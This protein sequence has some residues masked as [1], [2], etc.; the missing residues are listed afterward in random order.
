MNMQMAADNARKMHMSKMQNDLKHKTTQV[1]TKSK[2]QNTQVR[3]LAWSKTMCG[4]D[5]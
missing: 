3:F 1:P 2:M 4:Y 5:P